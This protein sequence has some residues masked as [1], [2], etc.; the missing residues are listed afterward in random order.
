VAAADEDD[1]ARD[2][3]ANRQG[4]PPTRVEYASVSVGSS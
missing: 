2:G 1:E 3:S 4:V